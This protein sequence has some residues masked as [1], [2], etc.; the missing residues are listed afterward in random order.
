MVR[1][2]VG[3]DAVMEK[4]LKKLNDI[5]ETDKLHR[6][7]LS[8]LSHK[9]TMVSDGLR[10]L[11]DTSSGQIKAVMEQLRQMG[12]KLEKVSATPNPTPNPPTPTLTMNPSLSPTL[13]PTLKTPVSVLG[14][15]GSKTGGNGGGNG[16]PNGGNGSKT[17]GNGGPN[18]LV[19]VAASCLVFGRRLGKH[20]LKI[21]GLV[22]WSQLS[23]LTLMIY[24]FQFQTLTLMHNVY[25]SFVFE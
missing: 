25:V 6:E 23:T 9:L 16:G 22:V 15:N 20:F 8:I 24:W 4:I 17:G 10:T 5:Q 14:G 21:K 7:H 1:G 12:E 19:K 2:N 13:K 18:E 11:S 3:R